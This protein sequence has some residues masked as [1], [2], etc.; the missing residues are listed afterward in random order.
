MISSFSEFEKMPKSLSH[1]HL[2]EKQMKELDKSKWVVTEKAHGANFSFVYEDKKIHFAKRKDYLAWQDDFFGFQ[3]VASENEDKILAFFEQLSLDFH[4]EKYILYGEL[5]GGKYPHSEIKANENLQA[6]QTGVYYSPNIAF[7]AF[8]IAIEKN[9]NKIYLDYEI[10]IKYFEKFHFL[11]AKP[12]FIGKFTESVYFNTR[13]NSTIPAM[14]HLPAL[15][16][17][18][19]EG[20]VIKLYQNP[21]KIDYSPRIILKIKNA[22][23]EEEKKFHEAEKWSYIPNISVKSEDLAF[24]LEEMRTYVSENRLNSV[25]PK[26]GSLNISN[27]VEIKGEFLQ[28]VWTDFNENYDG[29]LNDLAVEHQNW[30]KD[31]IEAEIS[32]LIN[33]YLKN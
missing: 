7:Y 26:I 16:S 18:L 8:D 4:A 33:S 13:I 29:M 2:N 21:Q 30:L 14:L 19:I 10:S 31:R 27:L 15:E 24:I 17:N 3:L 1:F 20:I 5:I 28:D 11:Y 12:L 22:E 32:Q 25:S 9:G 23:F 6:I